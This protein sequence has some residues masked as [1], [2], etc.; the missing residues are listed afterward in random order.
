MII[1]T[2]YDLCPQSIS[3][4]LQLQLIRNDDPYG[5][6]FPT[7]SMKNP[8]EPNPNPTFTELEL[9]TNLFFEVLRTGIEP[10]PY[11]QRTQPE[12]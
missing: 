4:Y 2:I 1:N 8:P 3:W 10:N 7:L 9:N 6:I 11:R 5:N 12:Y